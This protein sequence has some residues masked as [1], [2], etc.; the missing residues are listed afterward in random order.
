[1]SYIFENQDLRQTVANNE[2]LVEMASSNVVN[3]N[4]D[5]E[6]YVYEN[7]AQFTAGANELVDIYENVR[8]FIISENTAL[9]SQLSEI[10]ADSQLT[11][12]EKAYCLQENKFIDGA[13]T[14]A[15]QIFGNSPGSSLLGDTRYAFNV[16]R[17]GLD[18][19]GVGNVSNSLLPK[20]G[21]Y[22]GKNLTNIKAGGAVGGV[23]LT[24]Y[25]L[26]LQHAEK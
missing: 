7:L 5:L 21:N 3:Y 6:S 13:K 25:G 14:V 23:G 15:S 2:A 26:G 16:G 12:E 10:L 19:N 22:V 8:N 17:L 20:L 24:G 18:P 4:L 1:M 11:S 9:Y